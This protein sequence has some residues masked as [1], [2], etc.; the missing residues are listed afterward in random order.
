MNSKEILLEVAAK[1]PPDASLA[2]AI[3]ELEIRNIPNI[4]LP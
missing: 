1:P 3:Y 2:D 4:M